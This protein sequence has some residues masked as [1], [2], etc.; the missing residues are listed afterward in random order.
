M[1]RH[2][3]KICLTV[4]LATLSV[5]PALAQ[6]YRARLNGFNELGAL[7]AETGAILTDGTGRLTIDVD[8]NNQTASYK[9]TYSKL[10]SPV[11]QADLHFGKVHVP[12]GIYAFLC[13]T[14]GIM[15]P[16]GT[17][18]CPSSGGTVT[19]TINAAS[20]LA[21]APPAGRT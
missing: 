14:S 17:P 2:G 8:P 16:A 11:L 21:P 13:T 15:A 3:L 19:G 9:L 6:E 4:A 7:N 20:I 5:G 10:T 18:T 1:R 12:G